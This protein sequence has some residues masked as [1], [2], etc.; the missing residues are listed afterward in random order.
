M[1]VAITGGNGKLGSKVVDQLNQKHQIITFGRRDCDFMWTLGTL[2]TLASLQHI[3]AIFHF[4]WSLSDR[5]KD[6][7]LNIGGTMLL[8]QRAAELGIPFLFISSVAALSNS[9]YGKA[10]HEAEILV[11]SLGGV[12]MR[13][14]LVPEIADYGV[15]RSTKLISFVPKLAVDVHITT[16]NHLLESLNGWLESIPL[17]VEHPSQIT[18]VSKTILFQELFS[19]KIKI[20]INVPRGVIYMCLKTTNRISLKSRNM[21]DSYISIYT[22]PRNLG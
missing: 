10:K 4:G 16:L 22:T 13:I 14:G 19:G 3:D 15:P 8:A 9:N 21:L 12:S 20:K 7:D 18:L 2:P 11:R 17:K 1:R 6:I 5:G